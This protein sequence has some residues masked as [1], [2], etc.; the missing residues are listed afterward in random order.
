MSISTRAGFK[1][2][3]DLKPYLDKMNNNYKFKVYYEL[4]CDWCTDKVNDCFSNGKYCH[5]DPDGE[6]VGIGREIVIE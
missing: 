5:S 2:L 1:L 4:T 3:R 6:E